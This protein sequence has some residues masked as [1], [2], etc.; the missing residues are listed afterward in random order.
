MSD[1]PSLG[2]GFAVAAISAY[3][4]LLLGS[5]SFRLCLC[6]DEVSKKIIP[7]E[8]S[9]LPRDPCDP[10]PSPPVEARGA[11]AVPQP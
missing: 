10:S 4:G 9:N 11:D 7:E 1:G 5:R 8:G 6:Y 2:V 3:V